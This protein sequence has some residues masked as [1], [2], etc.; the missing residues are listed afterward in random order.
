MLLFKYNR[1]IYLKILKSIQLL[2]NYIYRQLD[3]H[4]IYPMNNFLIKQKLCILGQN[5]DFYN[6]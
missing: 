2:K 5:L 6:M 4:S 1:V 3:A